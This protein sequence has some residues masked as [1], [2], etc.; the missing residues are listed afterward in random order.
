MKHIIFDK[1]V[2]KVCNTYRVSREDL[3]STSREYNIV[4]ARQVLFYL[5][6]KRG[7]IINEIM[8]LMKERGRDIR[9]PAIR[10]GIDKV[11]NALHDDRDLREYIEDMELS[12]Y[13]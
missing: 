9:Y 5:S 1:Y 7:I 6:Y 8:R 4:T 13:I 2:D 11:Q 10:N 3:F 12:V